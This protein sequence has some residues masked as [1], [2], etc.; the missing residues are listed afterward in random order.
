MLLRLRAYNL[1]AQGLDGAAGP[2]SQFRLLPVI[3]VVVAG[4]D[5][6]VKPAVNL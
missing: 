1:T 5:S 2:A 4:S 3:L 6:T